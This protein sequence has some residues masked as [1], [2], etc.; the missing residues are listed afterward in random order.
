MTS[1][2]A[3]YAT[4]AFPSCW[5]A[6]STTNTCFHYRNTETSSRGANR[7]N[8]AHTASLSVLSFIAH[9]RALTDW[10]CA[11]LDRTRIKEGNASIKNKLRK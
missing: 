6:Q 1:A 11:A 2:L 9:Q 5:R 10:T 3:N 7:P 8:S 4:E